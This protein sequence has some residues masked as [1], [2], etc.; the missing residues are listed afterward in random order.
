MS[1]YNARA[2]VKKYAFDKSHSANFHLIIEIIKKIKSC[3]LERKKENEFWFVEND[4]LWYFE[5]AKMMHCY[6]SDD[7]CN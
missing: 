3:F 1:C 5:K 2:F 6:F 7:K 4:Q